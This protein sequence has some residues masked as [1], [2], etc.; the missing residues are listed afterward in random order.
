MALSSDNINTV[1]QFADKLEKWAGNLSYS[2]SPSVNLWL[3]LTLSLYPQDVQSMASWL[4]GIPTKGQK[5]GK[6]LEELSHLV[7]K[8]DAW[9]YQGIYIEDLGEFCARVNRLIKVTM[10][11]ISILRNISGMK[12]SEPPG[13]KA[14]PAEKSNAPQT[15]E[16]NPASVVPYYASA[17][18]PSQ[19]ALTAYKLH[20]EMGLTIQQVA[21]RMTAELKLDKALRQWQISRWIKQVEN[22]NISM[23]IPIRS[24]AP[25][26][27]G[28]TERSAKKKL[29][30]KPT[31]IK[32]SRP[33]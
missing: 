27:S 19:Q 15:P 17:M 8:V 23:H 22:Q 33:R 30:H 3:E 21:K 16:T 11:I 14:V 6:E 10:N 20:Y 1:S 24:V 26:A 9:R 2:T 13:T 7:Q 4:A 12:E 31:R 29:P 28:T 32:L 25:R 5:A 18:T